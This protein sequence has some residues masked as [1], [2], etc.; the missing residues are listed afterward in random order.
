M[1]TK[2]QALFVPLLLYLIIYLFSKKQ[3]RHNFIA[4]IRQML[5]ENKKKLNVS[6]TVHHELTIQQLP[7]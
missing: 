4:V 1:A 7:T 6:L 5:C 3:L 2:V